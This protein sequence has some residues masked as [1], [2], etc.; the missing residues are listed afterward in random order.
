M[1]SFIG[2]WRKQ[3]NSRKTS[4]SASL[5]TLNP[6]TVWITTNWKIFKE[7][8]IPDHLTCL[9]R[10]LY[11]R[12]EPRVRTRHETTDCFQTGK[13]VRQDCIL[14]PCLFNY[15]QSTSCKILDWKKHKLESRLLAE[16]SITSHMQLTPPL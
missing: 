8:A 3:G 16:V 11:A 5:T 9:L 15:M 12:Q 14:S 1:H 7:M 4:T 10:N 2:L 6:L 13:G